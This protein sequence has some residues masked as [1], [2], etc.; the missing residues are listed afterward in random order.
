[1]T[2]E[3][4]VAA[5]HSDDADRVPEGLLVMGTIMVIAASFVSVCGVNVQ[6]LAHNRNQARPPE[7]RRAMAKDW[8]WW[9]GMLLMLAGSLLDLVALPFVPQSRVSALGA[10]G[11][12]ANVIVTPLFLKERV[13]P[14]D[15]AGCAVTTVGCTVACIFGASAE[16]S[17]SSNCLLEYFAAEP[18]IIY[19]VIILLLLVLLM[20][21]IEGFRRK[22]NAVIAA[23]LVHEQN[24]VFDT[25]WAHH[26]QDRVM[27]VIEY[28]G[29]RCFLYL[30][31]RGPQFYPTVHVA[32]A[33]IAGAQSIMLAKA[34]LIFLGNVFSGP[35]RAKSGGLLMLFLVPFAA[36]LWLQVTFLNI[37]LKIYP[38]A[39]FVL[40]VYQSFWIVFGIASGLI[41]YQEY[42]QISNLGIGMFTTGVLVSL[43][44][45]AI[46]SKRKSR[47][48]L[49]SA[50][51][52][53]ADKQDWEAEA[54][55]DLNH[56]D[57]PPEYFPKASME[58]DLEEIP[59][60]FYSAIVT[61]ANYSVPTTAEDEDFHLSGRRSSK[62]L[63]IPTSRIEPLK[64][65]PDDTEYSRSFT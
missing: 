3:C 19:A 6:K 44:G 45:V 24:H 39:L 55:V 54:A 35:Q 64:Q 1:M 58:T 65:K 63:Y 61:A 31:N 10:A 22:K 32:L 15:I 48:H 21:L 33:G 23:G 12:V 8:L 62:S 41:Y 57:E 43:A 5:I 56:S 26:N 53:T 25:R 52:T 28:P 7:E 13:S 2:A 18:F 38:D 42:R 11:I 59:I 37:A 17:L 16:P 40:P 30:P 9:S 34:V 60:M 29:R 47:S 50:P 4:S 49:G 14:F 51:Q 20:Y 46:L 36:C 27:S